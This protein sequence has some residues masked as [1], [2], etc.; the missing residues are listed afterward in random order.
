MAGAHPRIDGLR[1]GVVLQGVDSPGEFRAMVSAIDD[2]GFDQLWLTDSSLHAR[3]P[4]SYL[5]L[6]S[7]VSPRLLVG[8]AVTNP[9]TR[10]PAIVTTSI[11]TVDDV[12]G[13]R[14][15]LGIGV[16]DRPLTA[17]GLEPAKV[18]DLEES[19]HAIRSLLDGGT[20]DHTGSLFSLRNAH[21]EFPPSSKIPV[22]VSA[23]GPRTLQLAGRVADG[24]ILLCGL[25]EA[26]ISW[27]LERI[28]EGAE[29][30]GRDRPHVA[31][32]A[33]GCI[34][35]DED[36]ALAAA[37]PI[38]AWF[39]QTVPLYCE[40]AG[41]DSDVARAVRER[42][43]G[44]EFQQAAEA[45][46]LLPREFVQRMALAGSRRRSTEQL[47]ALRKTG[48][49]SIHVFPLGDDRGTTIQRFATCLRESAS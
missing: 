20:V 31:L 24:V 28:D 16:G 17:L 49:D 13:G 22:F 6:A 18:A 3:D 12:S 41:L 4:Y 45:A 21:L 43:V 30:A 14:A 25:A 35:D 38:A 11:A 39:P 32:F 33:Y 48:V 40:L 34:D 29:A 5:C 7:E 46:R 1:S 44:G 19:I 47:R 37:A 8:T 36:V 9:M 23:S 10:H 26:G 27:A 2:A 15:V 42:Y